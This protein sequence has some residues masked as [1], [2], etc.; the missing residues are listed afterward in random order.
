MPIKLL[1]SHP[2]PEISVAV[3]RGVS[4]AANAAGAQ[5]FVGGATARDILTTHRFGIEQSRA[6]ADVD[7]GVSIGSWQGDRALRATLVATG[8]FEQSDEA[9]RL[10]YVVPGIEHRMW[11]D[12]VPFGGIEE[13]G[14]REIG[15]PPDGAVRMNVAGFEEALQAALEIELASDLVVLVVSL[16]ALAMLKIIAWRDR[17]TQH[18]RDAT[19]LRFLLAKYA[20]AGN[21]DRLYAGDAMDLLEA[22]GFDPD[23]AGAALLARDMASLVSPAIRAQVVETLSPG[24]AYPRILNQMLGGGHRLLLLDAEKPGMTEQLFAAFRTTL[25]QEFAARS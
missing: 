25:E 5:W 16:P 20:E 23:I 10:N 4:F 15:W 1:D 12:I 7:I 3:L 2:F 13:D 24:E 6:T 11:L 9:Q 21:H 8:R 14:E 18:A 22:H 17:H 19:D